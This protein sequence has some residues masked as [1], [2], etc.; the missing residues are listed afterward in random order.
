[1]SMWLIWEKNEFPNLSWKS[2]YI[3]KQQT[4]TI[5]KYICDTARDNSCETY[6]QNV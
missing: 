3:C 1:M 6:K 4:E 5:V 2:S